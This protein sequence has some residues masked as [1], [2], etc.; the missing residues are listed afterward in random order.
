VIR[1]GWVGGWGIDDN[2]GVIEHPTA[3]STDISTARGSLLWLGAAL[4]LIIAVHLPA[5]QLGF[6][7]D[8]FEWWLETR[9]RM[10]DPARALEPFGGLR[11]TNPAMLASDQLLW[12]TWMPGWH[13]TSLAIH[14]IVAVLVFGVARRVGFAVPAAAVVVALWGT[15]PYTVFMVREVH[16]RHDP[17]LLGCGLGLALL[18][19]GPSERW[20]ARRLVAAA[21][22]VAVSAVTKES[23]VVLPGFAA[24][25][26]LAF[27][28]RSFWPAVRT[29]VIWSVPSLAFVAAYLMRPAVDA[30]Y[31]TGYYSG[32]MRT[33][34]KIPST[35][36]A[37]CGLA[38]LDTSSLRFA[39]ADMV[40]LAVL[41]VVT[42]IALRSRSS[43]LLVGVA[44]FMLPLIPLVPVPVMGVHYGYASFVGFLLMAD[45]FA[46]LARDRA[47][48][49]TGRRVVAVVAGGVA[50][51]LFLS[52]MVT[53]AGEAADARRRADANERLVAEAEA[54]LPELPWDRA[55]VCVR[56]ERNVVTAALI[57]QVEGLPK[58]YFNRGSYP[59]GLIGW[60]ELFSWVCDPRG[61]PLWQEV[62]P[63][64]VGSD[65]FDVVGHAQDRFVRLPA[66]KESAAEEAA[67][68]AGRGFPVRVI[69]PIQ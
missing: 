3:P 34:T 63:E 47:G 67:V 44:F 7:G 8:D 58:T 19:P 43:A 35:L 53:M 15:S 9:Y 62:P 38:D 25:Y 31:A 45:G 33:A 68:W 27:R 16:V 40:A 22:L 11:L 6:V 24:A 49:V 61:G 29:G 56:L 26:E 64:E 52:G 46:Q 23:W 60:A 41:V 42:L 36:A 50:A 55:L 59:Y 12:G 66:E 69:R 1:N 39:A 37:F 51:A 30:S 10:A 28:R 5:L 17:L 57:D 4:L 13:L 2:G 48:S 14:G 20:T 54:F 18:W 32:G 21:V 65:A